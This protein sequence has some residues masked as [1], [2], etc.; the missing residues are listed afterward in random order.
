VF[1]LNYYYKVLGTTLVHE[2]NVFIEFRK[3]N[4]FRG[5]RYCCRTRS[6]ATC[7]ALRIV[8]RAV[9]FGTARSSSERVADRAE[10]GARRRD[11][12]DCIAVPVQGGDEGVPKGRRRNVLHDE[13]ARESNAVPAALCQR[14]RFLRRAGGAHE[15]VRAARD[16]RAAEAGA[17]R[18]RGGEESRLCDLRAS[19]GQGR[20]DALRHALV[21]EA[22]QLAAC[23]T[24]SG[25]QVHG[26]PAIDGSTQQ[27]LSERHEDKEGVRRARSCAQ[28][29]RCRSERF[30]S[31][32]E[33]VATFDFISVC[34]NNKLVK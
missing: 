3:T 31:R 4:G 25:H 11:A 33:T 34:T 21:P 14:C 1:V 9:R 7:G 17:A 16:D 5:A 27:E 6:M 26:V 28:V 24:E 23:A 22:L 30:G 32:I 8:V 10:G 2:R 29:S 19:D 20:R 15:V 18:E 12:T 13:S